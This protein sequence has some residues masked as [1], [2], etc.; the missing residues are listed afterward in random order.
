LEEAVTRQRAEIGDLRLQV[1][2]LG[3]L[4]P[5]SGLPNLSGVVDLVDAAGRR[6]D[7]DGEPFG[8]MALDVPG[9]EAGAVRRAGVVLT[10]AL[11]RVD[12][13]GW[14]GDGGFVVVLPGLKEPGAGTVVA[15][16][17]VV[18]DSVL[19]RPTPARIALVL[20][21]RSPAP[22][23]FRVVDRARRLAGSAS[24]GN[25]VVETYAGPLDW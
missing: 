14:A 9:L 8:V 10:A 19:E 13:P 21:A 16:V 25:P 7:R 20:C 17:V 5:L 6:L 4:D 23:A 15:R 2:V 1:D 12:R 3:T 11:R 22:E 18:L 24:A